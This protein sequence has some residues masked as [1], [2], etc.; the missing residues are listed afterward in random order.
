MA[1]WSSA[2]AC[3]MKESGSSAS[4]RGSCR[5]IP[6]FGISCL[7]VDQK[8]SGA[9]SKRCYPPT[10]E[11]GSKGPVSSVRQ[12]FREVAIIYSM[13]KIQICEIDGASC[14]ALLLSRFRHRGAMQ[15]HARARLIASGPRWGQSFKRASVPADLMFKAQSVCSIT[16]PRQAR[17]RGRKR[18]SVTCGFL[19]RRP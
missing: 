13:G 17:S 16:N 15:A 14:Y 6:V 1:V 18:R 10:Q 3:A 4:V 5:C 19:W 7:F 9:R 11:C 8:L 12:T 2:H